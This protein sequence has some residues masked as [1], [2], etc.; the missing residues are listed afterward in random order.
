MSCNCCCSKILK[1]CK[2]NACDSIDFGITAQ[3]EGVHKL[4]LDFLGSLTTLTE[5]FGNGDEII[6]PV[7]DLNE[8]MIFTARLYQPDGK[9][10]IISKDGVEYD[11][12]EFKTIINVAA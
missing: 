4:V 12:F 9:Q 7:T 10:I 11:C 6:F 1:L 3:A 8:N 2:V 5:T